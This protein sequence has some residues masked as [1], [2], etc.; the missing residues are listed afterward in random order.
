MPIN[1]LQQLKKTPS[2]QKFEQEN[3]RISNKSALITRKQLFDEI[4]IVN[5]LKVRD[6]QL[7]QELNELIK[8][9]Y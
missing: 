9:Y 7:I 4:N 2:Q 3:S 1:K 6:P 8:P 5:F